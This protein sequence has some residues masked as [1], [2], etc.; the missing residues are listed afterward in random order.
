MI[1]LYGLIDV[2]LLHRTGVTGGS[3]TLMTEGLYQGSRWGLKGTEDL[4]GGWAALFQLENG[5]AVFNGK[6]DQQGQLFG[7]QAWVGLSKTSGDFSNTLSL[8]RQYG[9][10]FALLG[11]FDALYFPNDPLESWPVALMGCRFDNT[12]EYTLRTKNLVA[13]LQYSVGGQPGSVSVGSTLS[14]GATYNIGPANVG[15]SI[16]QSK[17]ATGNTMKFGGAGGNVTVGKLKLYGLY[18]LSL[19]DPNFSP[20]TSGTTLPLANTSLLSNVGNPN[21]RRDEGFDFGAIYSFTPAFSGTVSVLYDK[22]SGAS[23]GDGGLMTAYAVAD[24]FL[25]K[26]TDVYA[27]IDY[28]RLTGA[29]VRD[30]NVPSGSFAG[31]RSRTGV[32]LGIRTKF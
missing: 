30:P 22:V 8:G 15:F 2:Q 1:P 6:L 19:R 4:G 28:S 5:L 17:D 16:E 20:G 31:A 29:E 24:Y 23:G 10:P 25:S 7:R 27:E 13:M 9:I 21:T 14:A 18:I 26:R 12:I 3:Q 11:N 32:G